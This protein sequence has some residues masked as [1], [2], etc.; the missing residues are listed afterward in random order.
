MAALPCGLSTVVNNDERTIFAV[1]LLAVLAVDHVAA[2]VDPQL[3]KHPLIQL[4]PCHNKPMLRH[5]LRGLPWSAPL[6]LILRSLYHSPYLG[7]GMPEACL[8]GCAARGGG[9][10]FLQ[11]SKIYRSGMVFHISSRQRC[12]EAG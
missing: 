8:T 11:R 5:P 9:V 4:A 12:I 2:L 10:G 3:V 7:G 1:D 6:P